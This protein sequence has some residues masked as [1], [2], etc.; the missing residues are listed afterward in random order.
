MD[1]QQFNEV[2]LDAFLCL[3]PPDK[4]GRVAELW[5]GGKTVGSWLAAVGY[6]SPFIGTLDSEDKL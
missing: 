5:D 4:S 3:S 1:E 6:S 2:H